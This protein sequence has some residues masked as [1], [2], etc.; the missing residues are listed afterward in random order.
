M[1]WCLPLKVLLFHVRGHQDDNTPIDQLPYKVQL[2]IWCDKWACQ[3]LTMLLTNTKLHPMLPAAYPHL[4]INNQ[5]IVRQI[6]DYLRKSHLLPTYKAYL[7]S[8]FQWQESISNQIKWQTMEY[9]MQKLAKLDHIPIQTIVH[10]WTPTQILPDN[11]LDESDQLCL[12]CHHK[13]EQPVH[14]L[15]CTAN[16]RL[17]LQLKF[18]AKLMSFCHKHNLDP[19]WYQMWWLGLTQPNST[20]EHG[21][22]LLLWAVD[23]LLALLDWLN[24]FV[25][26]INPWTSWSSH[27]ALCLVCCINW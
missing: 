4:Y 3:N 6:L 19:N 25:C 13:L 18:K 15:Q 12:S 7:M 17:A 14:L 26:C 27:L 16:T 11:Y 1:I 23:S 24:F 9:A 10:E 22:Q 21:I 8:K 20:P 5:V 2:N